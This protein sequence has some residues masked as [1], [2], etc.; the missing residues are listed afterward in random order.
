MTTLEVTD[1]GV[2]FGEREI[3]KNL[4]L[5]IPSGSYAALLG[6][7]GCGKT[8]LLR[9]IAGLIRPSSGAIRFGKKLVSVSSLVLPPHKRN[10]GY[11]PQEDGLFPH[12]T[13]G[14]NIGFALTRNVQVLER[15][16]IIEEMMDLVGLN[17]FENRKPHELSG[18]QQTRVAL[19]R[20]LATKPA[21]VLLDEP[22][23]NLDQA[24]RADVSEEVVALLKRTKTT[25]LMVTH[26]REDALVSAD[27][28]ALMREGHV[29]Q[30]GTPENVYM[31]PISAE[32]AEST[33]DVIELPAKRFKGG[34]LVSP[35]HGVA[36]RAAAS[37]KTQKAELGT[38]LIRPEEIKVHT[39]SRK[40]PKAIIR[41]IHYYGHDA[42]LDLEI[43]GLRK[44]LRV[45]VGGPISYKVGSTVGV[46][47]F[48]PIRW[49]SR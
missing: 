26:D 43:S 48:G 18:G 14:E 19:A 20:A 22:F 40:Y 35:L 10:I 28:I 47:H 41:E 5:T 3:L 34:R 27:V 42:I 30:F 16:A 8:T 29:V 12:L 21:I 45:R 4:S 9:T 32:I 11:L 39:P 44:N 6:P 25:S 38:L 33:G 49:V 1:L 36:S 2:K 31:Q 13:V 7:S 46:E 15:K 37:A 24:L 23:S 17:G